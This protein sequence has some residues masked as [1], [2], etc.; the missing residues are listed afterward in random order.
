MAKELKKQGH[1]GM[2]EHAFIWHEKRKARKKAAAATNSAE[3]KVAIIADCDGAVT[4]EGID[5]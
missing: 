1:W 5:N 2:S 4:G 3:V